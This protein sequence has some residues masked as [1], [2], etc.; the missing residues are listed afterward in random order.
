MAP[1]EVTIKNSEEVFMNIY[2]KKPL[3][4]RKENTLQIGDY[5]RLS[6]LENRFVKGYTQT[7]SDEIFQIDDIK[8]GRPDVYILSDFKGAVIRGSVYFEELQKIKYL[9]EDRELFAIEKILETRGS[10]IKVRWRGYN[11]DFDSW[12]HK[13][14]IERIT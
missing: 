12:I 13:S 1:R 10:L 6:R 5:V 2:N 9:G 11:S 14:T 8:K 3:S 4:R 7:W